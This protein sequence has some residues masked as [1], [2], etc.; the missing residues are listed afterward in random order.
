MAKIA[1][2]LPSLI[3]G[4]VQRVCLNLAREFVRLGLE[5]DLVVANA[6]GHLL[7]QIPS[8][9][10]LV[11]LGARSVARS[12]PALV[13][14][15]KHSI[16][17]AL[18]SALDYANAVAIIASKIARVPKRVVVSVHIKLPDASNYPSCIRRYM[19][20]FAKRLVYR[21]ADKV[22]AVSQGLANDYRQ[23]LGIPQERIKVI[24]NPIITPD[25]MEKANEPVEHPWF[26]PNMPPV[27]LGVGRLTEQKDFATLIRAFALV[28]Q[29]IEARLVILGEGELRQDLEALI[30]KLGLQGEVDMPGFVDNPYAYMKRSAVFVLSS[31]WEG[32]GNVLVEAMACGVPVVSTNCPYGPS[33][34]LEGGRLG[35]LVPVG[36]AGLLA[37]TIIN[38]L[39]SKSIYLDSDYLKKYNL[40]KCSKE[41]I[42]TLLEDYEF[43]VEET[44]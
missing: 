14:Y 28:R 19:T 35:K 6:E 32:F 39:K 20:P 26:Q 21:W 44:K 13:R 27:I 2:Y 12:L 23:K 43:D 36:D 1:I 31:R 8:Q 25:L 9:V 15:L 42:L 34:I 40:N 30:Q 10:G 18:L 16:P 33:E 3:G 37:E 24:Y 5:V 29:Q 22:V 41:Y 38:T 4:G 7:K 17:D 11:D